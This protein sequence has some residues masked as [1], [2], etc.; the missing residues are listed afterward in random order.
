MLHAAVG[1]I[2]ESDVNLA[3]ANGALL[4]GF[5][6][7]VDAKA[8]SAAN[9]EGV[10]PELFT[11]IYDVLDRVEA[12]LKGK[13]APV[14]EEVRQGTLEVR[15]LFKISKI[16]TIAGSYVIDGKVGRNHTAK[17]LRE[18]SVIWEGDV[19]TLKRFKDDVR[20]VSAGYECGVSLEGFNDLIE[21]D[22]IETYSRE[23]V[24]P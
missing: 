13:L 14:Y 6:V 15:A 16:G 1:P 7:L 2:S 10:E 22:L 3:S 23:L 18:G 19:A 20:E 8:R 21:G 17:V 4:L 5:H 12:E 24:E 9:H 11:V